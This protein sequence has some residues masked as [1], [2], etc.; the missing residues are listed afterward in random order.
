MEEM[1]GD[2]HKSKKVA[3]TFDDGYKSSY[4]EAVPV[5]ENYGFK[6]IFFVIT[7]NIEKNKY[8][9]TWEE[10]REIARKGHEIQSHTHNHA[11]LSSLN[12]QAIAYELDESKLQIQL[13]TGKTPIVLSCPGGRYDRRLENIA[14]RAGYRRIF[15]SKPEYYCKENNADRFILGRH[16]ITETTDIRQ[17]RQIVNREGNLYF[18]MKTMYFVKALA[19]KVIGEKLSKAVTLIVKNG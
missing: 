10:V 9:M 2:V 5:M 4:H 8:F 3:I 12:D 7:N 1:T 15:T 17:F 19:R 18:R 14:Q 6:G 16:T 11:F 13:K